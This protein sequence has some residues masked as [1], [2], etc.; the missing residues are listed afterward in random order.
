MIKTIGRGMVL[1]TLTL[2]VAGCAGTGPSAREPRPTDV[3]P[4]DPEAVRCIDLLRVDRTDVVD[5][6]NVFF[7]MKN[8][9]VYR[10]QLPYRCPGLAREDRF[11]YKPHANRLCDLDLITVLTDFGGGLGQ[12]ASCG[13]GRFHPVDPDEV[14]ALI[15][16]L[17]RD[18]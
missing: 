1:S 13:L 2:F 10:N 11:L 4:D 7:Y 18:E 3:M 9:T 14:E 16:V 8:G 12:G 6:E 15:E 17:Q 5:D